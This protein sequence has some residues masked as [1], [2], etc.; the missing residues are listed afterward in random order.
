MAL[1][2]TT[3]LSPKSRT[4]DRERGA[5]GLSSALDSGESHAHQND[6]DADD[7]QNDG[8][9]DEHGYEGNAGIG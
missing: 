2:T 4:D 1:S 7:D 3:S 6:G 5:E 8:C 9:G